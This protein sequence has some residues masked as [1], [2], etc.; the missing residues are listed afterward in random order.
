MKAFN[1]LFDFLKRVRQR[2]VDTLG[3]ASY[4]RLY[5]SIVGFMYGLIIY[6]DAIESDE[7]WSVNLF[8]TMYYEYLT[9]RFSGSV[10]EEWGTIAKLVACVQPDIQ[11]PCYSIIDPELDEKVFYKYFEIYDEFLK[12]N[13]NNDL[14]WRR[15]RPEWYI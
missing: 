8:S 14:S 11:E 2:P 6:E 13:E 5:Y 12:H 3:A 10:A 4:I 1:N 9:R 15:N 7:A